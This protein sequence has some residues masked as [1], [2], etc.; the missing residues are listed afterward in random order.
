MRFKANDLE[1]IAEKLDISPTMYEYAVARYQGIS[2]YL[3]DNGIDADF[4]PQG[5]FRT[6]TVVRP[7]KDGIET[8]FDIDVICELSSK[9]EATTPKQTK[10]TVGQALEKNTVYKEKLQPEEDR[11]WTL[12]YA[13]VSDGI[14]FSLDV[15]PS[16]GESN[17]AI[18]GLINSGVQIQ[19]AGTALAI[20]EK[21]GAENYSWLPS[22]PKGFGNWFD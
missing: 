18:A 6:G 11:C 14:G 9:K 2:Q 4:Y 3:A 21:R 20:T 7:I 12:K 16:V 1:T 19:Y 22:N 13:D 15:V 17:T 5:S 10:K 8:D